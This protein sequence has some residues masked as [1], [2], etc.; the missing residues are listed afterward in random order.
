M[1][2]ESSDFTNMS[3]MVPPATLRNTL[4]AKPMKKRLMRIVV[5]FCATAHGIIQIRHIKKEPM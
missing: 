4:P 5:I 1:G 3:P 2:I